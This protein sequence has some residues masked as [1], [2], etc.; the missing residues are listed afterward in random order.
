MAI[1]GEHLVSRGT[2]IF[3]GRAETATRRHAGAMTRR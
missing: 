2:A 3:S 1:F